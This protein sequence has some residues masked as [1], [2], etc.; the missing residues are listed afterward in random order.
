[1]NDFLPFVSQMTFE[2]WMTSV[3]GVPVEKPVVGED[4]QRIQKYWR[5]KRK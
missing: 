3:V 1:M 5:R 4:L 2:F